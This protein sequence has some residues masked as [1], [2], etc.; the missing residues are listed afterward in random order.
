MAPGMGRWCAARTFAA[1]V[2]LAAVCRSEPAV[3][4][5]LNNALG[6]RITPD[7]LGQAF[8]GADAIG[9]ITGSPPSAPVL[10]GGDIIGHLLST[11]DS[12]QST[13]FA[14]EPFDIIVGVDLEANLVG[15]VLVEHHEPI[16]GPSMIRGDLMQGFLDRLISLSV[17]HRSRRTQRGEL[18]GVSGATVSSKLMRSAVLTSAQQGVRKLGLASQNIDARGLAVDLDFYV[19]RGWKEMAAIGDIAHLALR[20]GDVAAAFSGAATK[21]AALDAD[22]R[23]V[24]VYATLATPA[25]IGRN[26]WLNSRFVCICD[27][28]PGTS[29]GWI[30]DIR[31]FQVWLSAARGLT[32]AQRRE[33]LAV[34]SGRSEGEASKAAIELG[35]DEARRCPH[36]AS[37]G[38]V[39]RGMARGL[40]RYQCKGCGRTFNALS[41]TPLSGLHHKER[42]LSFGAS[43]AKGE[44]VKA[45]AARCD[46]AV[47]TAFRWRHRFLAAAR[48]DSE[49]L[50]GIVEADET[51]V[52]ESRKGARGLGRKARRRGGKA[53]KRSLSR[54]QVPVLMAADRS[55]TTV[56]AVLPRV[57]AAA[58]TAALDPVVAKDA[59]LV[60]DGGASYPPCAAALGVSH[61]ALNRSMGERVRGDLHVQTVNSRHSR[62]KD[63]LRPRRGIATRYLDNYL[64]WFHL[65]GLAPGANDR[66]CL[67][68]AVTR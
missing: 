67:A 19:E 5:D 3:A 13:G 68:A 12:V 32:R 53:K 45:S 4:A 2:L 41:G 50:K 6:A 25:G 21:L 27:R 35:V 60:S 55:G 49:V 66:A 20:N 33:A 24:D 26:L 28:I 1:A 43:L 29:G 44:T 62:L 10:F 17:V 46:V 63:F 16:I 36:C 7:V 40:R 59:L 58:L 9:E 61:E 23:F 57:D 48:S 47:S 14:G 65:V 30:M 37:E 15:V 31:G 54:E 8:P 56:S 18:D 51:Y 22:A 34:L 52:L 39:S 64:S 42:W 38:A 11:Y